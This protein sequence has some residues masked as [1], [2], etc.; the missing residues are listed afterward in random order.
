V[1]LL[2]E[3]DAA[4]DPFEQ[5]EA[6]FEEAAAAVPAPEAMV[7]ATATADGAPSARMVLMKQAS[8]DGFLFFTNY[9][10]RKA[11]ELDANPRAALLFYWQPLGRQ[12]RIEGPVTRVDASTSDAYYDSRPL[13]AR[14]GAWASPQSEV[15]ESRDVLEQSVAE[16]RERFGSQPARPPHWGGFRVQ[17]EVYEFW[18]HQDDRLHDRLRYRREAGSWVRERLAP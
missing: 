4:D 13:G 9:G 5:F 14:L 11:R 7:V 6:W 1:T 2:L 8:A 3:A 12:V 10:S 17:P 18:Q 16:A 15:I